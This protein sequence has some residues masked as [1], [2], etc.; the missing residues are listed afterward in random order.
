M[1]PVHE[2][3]DALGL[4]C[5]CRFC[6]EQITDKPVEVLGVFDRVEGYAHAGCLDSAAERADE[7][8]REDFYGSSS[9]QTDRER[10][11]VAQ[12]FTLRNRF[13]H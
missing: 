1:K 9:P 2:A 10:R 7:R 6:G 11:V 4:G 13:S 5:W 3:L 8:Q 12:A